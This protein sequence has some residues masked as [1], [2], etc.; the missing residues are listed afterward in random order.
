M[1]MPPVELQFG[2]GGE[3]V[4]IRS[5]LRPAFR[6]RGCFN[7]ATAAK[8]WRWQPVSV[9][10]SSPCTLQFGHGG[11]AVEMHP[12]GIASS[13]SAMLQFGHGGEAVEIGPTVPHHAPGACA[14][15]R[16]RRRSRGDHYRERRA[17]HR[18]DASIRPRRR[19]R[20]DTKQRAVVAEMIERLQFGHGGEAVEIR[21]VARSVRGVW[22][23]QFGHG[24]E[25]VEIP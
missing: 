24:G 15:I 9:L 8:P 18:R 2:H 13:R 23:L 19:S 21:T 17:A 25:A 4:E 5:S 1:K 20:G 6:S 10:T 22:P 7:S 11:E 3:A 14:S 16:P 12:S